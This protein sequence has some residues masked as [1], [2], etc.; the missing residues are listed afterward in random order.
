MHQ[1]GWKPRP[2]HEFK[3]E[4]E[5][6]TSEPAWVTYQG[7]TARYSKAMTD[8]TCRHLN[9]VRLPS[10]AEADRWLGSVSLPV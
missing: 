9:F 2:D 7:L 3:E 1:P 5:R 8:P 4:V 6:A 10:N